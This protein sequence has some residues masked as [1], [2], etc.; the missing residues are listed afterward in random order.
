MLFGDLVSRGRLWWCRVE[1]M[2]YRG[3]YVDLQSQR[4]IISYGDKVPKSSGRLH[5]RL[6]A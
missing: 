2:D 1:S 3:Y 5:R 6:G 4:G